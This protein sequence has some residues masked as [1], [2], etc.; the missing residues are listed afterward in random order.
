[1]FGVGRD[2]PLPYFPT[3]QE[4]MSYL[5]RQGSSSVNNGPPSP[6]GNGN[7]NGNN[8]NGALNSPGN[9]GSSLSPRSPVMAMM[10][11]PYQAANA[12]MTADDY[13][14]SSGS[15]AINALSR[16]AP[17]ALSANLA[18]LS[19][20]HLPRNHYMRRLITEAQQQSP[21]KRGS[22]RQSSLTPEK[23]VTLKDKYRCDFPF[24]VT[25]Y[26]FCFHNA[27]FIFWYQAKGEGVQ[28]KLL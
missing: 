2:I 25:T 3:T 10:A 9:N 24:F 7:S 19:T 1:V 16:T 22:S 26:H 15:S 8:G 27:T 23:D 12:R 4:Y 11:S 6:T 21:D 17:A 28:F 20:F 13:S 14:V 5:R 18:S